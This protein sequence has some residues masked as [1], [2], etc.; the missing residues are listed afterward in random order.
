M[1]F[2]RYIL[3][4]IIKNFTVFVN[5]SKEKSRQYREKKQQKN[6]KKSLDKRE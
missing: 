6:F 5:H 3:I 2:G 1:Y 4:G